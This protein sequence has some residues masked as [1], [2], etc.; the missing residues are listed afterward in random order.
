[1][2]GSSCS[3]NEFAPGHTG[4]GGD[5]RD[6]SSG[7]QSGFAHEQQGVHKLQS[8]VS[9]GMMDNTKGVAYLIRVRSADK[10]ASTFSGNLVCAAR[11]DFAEEEV[12]DPFPDC[13][14]HFLGDERTSS[15]D[16]KVDTHREQPSHR[17]SLKP[18][19]RGSE[20]SWPTRELQER[21]EGKRTS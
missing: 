1:M 17:P 13:A 7:R 11:L 3:A 21:K 4:F 16:V 9:I 18:G 14:Y 2:H 12:D 8:K 6:A 20:A 5:E 10:D 19:H 15:H